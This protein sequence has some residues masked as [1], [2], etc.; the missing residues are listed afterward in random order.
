VQQLSAKLIVQIWISAIYKELLQ[1]A[2]ARNKF[3]EVII[4]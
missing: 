2:P 4:I 1:Q 3:P